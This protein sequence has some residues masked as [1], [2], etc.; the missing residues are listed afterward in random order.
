MTDPVI[1]VLASR[2]A[3]KLREIEDVLGGVA[4]IITLD[5]AG[6][7]PSPA[8]DDIETF[9]TFRE[10]ALAKARYF[11]DI[12]GMPTIADDSGILFD[13]L[14]GAPGV[15]SRRF[16]MPNNLTGNDLDLANNALA[17]HRLSAFPQE[18][19]NAHY[20]CVAALV[21]AHTEPVFAV[22]S[23]S[24]LFVTTPRGNSGF[25]YD[26]HFL[27]PQIDRTF[28]ELSPAEKHRFSHRARAFRA[29]APLLH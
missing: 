16:S 2:S 9:D 12:T 5:E 29:I 21:R 8:E 24:G 26:P 6:V 4:R 3:H 22:G 17:T 1:F 20:I 23:C 7:S 11:F 15:R 28:G 13:A 25:G 10:N 14:D 19:R 27:L 18:Q